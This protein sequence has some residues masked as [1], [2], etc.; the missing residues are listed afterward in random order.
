MTECDV[1]VPGP[2]LHTESPMYFPPSRRISA[3]EHISRRMPSPMFIICFCT[4]SSVHMVIL[5]CGAPGVPDDTVV[6]SHWPGLSFGKSCADACDTLTARP[7]GTVTA[8]I[9]ATRCMEDPIGGP[10]L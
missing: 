1:I 3:L 9:K 7:S 5:F 2:I 8:R 6:V 4:E 10:G